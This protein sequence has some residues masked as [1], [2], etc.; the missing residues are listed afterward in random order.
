MRERLGLARV[1]VALVEDY[2]QSL[3]IFDS[4]TVLSGV[5]SGR[6]VPFDA[7]TMGATPAWRRTVR[8][9]SPPLAKPSVVA[10]P[11]PPSSSI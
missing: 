11:S 4:T 3:R 9:P 1:S 5:E 10:V 7:G 8:K 2:G 6:R